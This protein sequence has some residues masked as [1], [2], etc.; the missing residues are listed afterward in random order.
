MDSIPYGVVWEWSRL[1]NPASK[2]S[3]HIRQAK[4]ERPEMDTW[5]MKLHGMSEGVWP[6]RVKEEDRF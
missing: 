1:S 4:Q 3:R 2:L 5:Q 6:K